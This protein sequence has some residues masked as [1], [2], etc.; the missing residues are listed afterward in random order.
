MKHWNGRKRADLK[1]QTRR[2]RRRNMRINVSNLMVAFIGQMC[3]KLH[4][5]FRFVTAQTHLD[6]VFG[7]WTNQDL[8]PEAGHKDGYMGRYMY[9]WVHRTLRSNISGPVGYSWPSQNQLSCFFGDSWKTSL[10]LK[11]LVLGGDARHLWNLLLN[12]YFLLF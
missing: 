11:L 1:R 2:M 9:L 6:N 8:G 4:P 12:I 7:Q 10:S 5:S 3:Q